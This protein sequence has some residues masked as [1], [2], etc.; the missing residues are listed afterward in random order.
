MATPGCEASGLE[1][2]ASG[3]LQFPPILPIPCSSTT[4]GASSEPRMC[5]LG[6]VSVLQ[7]LFR[8]AFSK[9]E[10]GRSRDVRSPAVIPKASGPAG[11][12]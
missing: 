8:V 11:D 9:M 5:D 10:Q 2:R 1:V 7:T 6:V 12:L 4:D 3:G